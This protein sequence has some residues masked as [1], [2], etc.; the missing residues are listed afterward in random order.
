M[1]AG[2]SSRSATA[3]PSNPCLPPATQTLWPMKFMKLV[4]CSITFA[5]HALLPP[6]AA[7]WQSVHVFVSVARTVCGTN[8]LNAWPL[9]PSADT[10]CCM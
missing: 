1:I 3:T 5:I 2:G 8:V 7:T 10:V 4:P 9:N 6:S